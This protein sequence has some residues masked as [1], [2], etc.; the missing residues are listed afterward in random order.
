MTTAPGTTKPRSGMI[1][2]QG[3]LCGGLIAWMPAMATLSAIL[4]APGLIAYFVDRSPNR[5]VGRSVLLFGAVLAPQNLL[6][7]WHAGN[8][9]A[10]SL[11]MAADIRRVATIWALQ[12]SGWMLAELTPVLVRLV[13][14]AK[15]LARRAQ[16]QRRRAGLEEEWSLP[17]RGDGA[18]QPTA[19]S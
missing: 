15:S 2:I 1:W 5:A 17:P 9:M 4:L 6:T 3:L 7:L 12:A 16:L 14:D 10:A 18:D 11:S 19:P 8:S 13:L